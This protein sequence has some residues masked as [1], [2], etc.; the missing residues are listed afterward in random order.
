MMRPPDAM[1]GTEVSP[2]RHPAVAGS[3][4][5]ADPVEL[6]ELVD[7]LLKSARP[8]DDAV[9]AVAAGLAGIL[10]PHAG[11]VYSGHV[12]AVA[13]RL[14]K[15]AWRLAANAAPDASDA[16]AT[17]VMLGTNHRA[18]WLQG[19]GAWEAA[20]DEDLAA[21]IVALGPPFMV[22]RDAHRSEHSLEVQLPFVSRT[23]PGAR[24]VPLAISAGRGELAVSAGA[25]LGVLLAERRTQGARI[26]LAISTDMAHYPPATIGAGVTE[27][28]APIILALEP[29]RL[30][31]REAEIADSG[32]R[33]VACGMCG[34]E[35]TVLGLAALRAMGV[36]RG[37]RLA[38]ATSADV[39]GPSGRTVGYLSVAFPG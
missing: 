6:A 20:V 36:E 2:V 33:G 14:A 22:D 17:I 32:L 9:A 10:V 3:F 1:P 13:W 8:P 29:T 25:R 21:E 31:H 18:G 28:L 16:P 35:P 27:D 30:A 12:A 26:C 37:I 39:G 34:I 23:R 4:Y 11:L 7:G 38:A 15:G 5:P 24:I 19:I